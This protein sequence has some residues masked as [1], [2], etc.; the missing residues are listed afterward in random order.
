MPNKLNRNKRSRT[1]FPATDRSKALRKPDSVKDVLAKLSPTLTRVSDQSSRQHFW[2]G[3]L[4]ERLADGLSQRLSGVVER[5]G[6]LVIFAESAAWSARLR[7]AV[8][9]LETQIRAA[10]PD[11]QL[12]TV[13]VLPKT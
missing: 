9:D 4:S 8:Q 3:W 10:Q 5:E 7:F 13:R 2:R 12:I 1:R 6:T 11:I